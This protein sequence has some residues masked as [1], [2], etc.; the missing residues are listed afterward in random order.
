MPVLNGQK[1]LPLCLNALKAQDYAG[2]LRVVVIND[3]STDQT[4][5]IAASYDNVL[6]INQKNQGRAAARNNGIEASSAEV[7]AF[8]DGDCAPRPD[9]LRNLVGRL[10]SSVQHGVVG[11]SVAL[12]EDANLWQ[13]LDHQAWAH[14]TGPEAP[15]GQ[16][17]LASTANMCIRRRVFE[18]VGG[19]NKLL[20]G[21]EDS[22]LALRVHK[23][24]YVNY[25]EPRAVVVHHH[26]RNTLASFMRQRF[27]YGKW[28]IQT[29]LLHKPLTPYSWMFFDS[30]V[31]LA[32]LWP[33]YSVLA[34]GFTVLKA[35][36]SDLSAL[37]LSPLHLLGRCMEYLGV[38]KGSLRY[39]K[40][41]G[42]LLNVK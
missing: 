40:K 11:G 12:P 25:F 21:S 10:L 3:G 4:A 30:P 24:G 23:S 13:R 6:L 31:F 22:D 5:R 9:W 19:F 28:T 27:N 39:R 2:P 34:T 33:L 29:V 16:S 15:S 42:N 26:P 35:G 17:L 38:I 8:T 18:Q 37:W 1:T 41:F 20:K 14:S 7:I 36:R 32:L